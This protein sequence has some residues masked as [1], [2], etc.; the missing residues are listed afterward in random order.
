MTYISIRWILSEGHQNRWALGLK[1]YG[2]IEYRIFN[3]FYKPPYGV[4]IRAENLMTNDG[5]IIF[6]YLMM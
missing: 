3:H 2:T 5:D 6:V 1:A 4:L